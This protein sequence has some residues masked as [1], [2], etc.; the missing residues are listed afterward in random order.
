MIAAESA[1]AGREVVLAVDSST[2]A[3][4]VIAFTG[5]GLRVAEARGSHDRVQP[6]PGHQEQDPRQWWSRLVTALREV[7]DQMQTGG[8]TP[9]ALCVSHQ[10]E[11]FALLDADGEP[12]RPAVLWLDTRACDQI[13]AL[14]SPE[15]HA[16]SGKPPSTTPSLY[17]L[18]WLLE[19]EPDSLRGAAQVVDVHGYLVQRLTGRAVTSWASADPLSLLD[20]RTF[21]WCDRLLRMAGLERTQVQALARPGEVMAGLSPEAASLTGL[22]EQLPVVAGCGDGQAAGLGAD[23]TRSGVAYL[24]LGTGFTLGTHSDAYMTSS[25]YRTLASP[26][27]GGYTLEALLSSGALSLSWFASLVGAASPSQL[28]TAAART[29]VGAGGLMFSPYLTSA[30][31]PHWDPEARGAFLGLSDTHSV[32]HLYRAVIEGLCMEEAISLTAIEQAT[33]VPVAE[34][35]TL[36]GAAASPLMAQVLVNVLERSLLICEETETTA[37]GAAALAAG[38][39][40]LDGYASATEAASAMSRL[41]PGPEPDRRSVGRYSELR[42]LYSEIYPVTR[43]LQHRLSRFRDSNGV[44]P[45]IT[46]GPA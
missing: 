41:R 21:E 15:V 18:A 37:L 10:R 46:G 17:K 20:M 26:V 30:E 19:H 5:D 4:K 43:D 23:A 13:A 39:V 44:D 11:T 31:T 29:P 42:D 25:A 35:H 1:T 34:V 38:A 33:G 40:G 28:E 22:P 8:H 3:T 6:H 14:G 36:G 27:A 32:G 7:A 2:T 16:L 24:N 45:A 9:V 12:V